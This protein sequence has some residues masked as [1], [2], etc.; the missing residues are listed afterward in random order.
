MPPNKH[1]LFVSATMRRMPTCLKQGS[2]PPSP[3]RRIPDFF[4]DL[5]SDFCLRS[6]TC[7][8]PSVVG[9]L[10]PFRL[11]ENLRCCCRRGW[12]CGSSSWSNTSVLLFYLQYAGSCTAWEEYINNA[13]FMNGELFIFSWC[14]ASNISLPTLC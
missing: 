3:D 8:S 10:S 7:S 11:V 6:S 13:S 2:S 1:V 14:K 9:N 12:F 4:G 5:D